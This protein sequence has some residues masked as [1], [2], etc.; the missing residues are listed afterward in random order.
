[1]IF[2]LAAL[3]CSAF[4]AWWLSGARSVAYLCYYLS[5]APFVTLS[6]T[7]GGLAG[8]DGF[9]SEVVLIKALLRVGTAA[10][11]VGLLVTRRSALGAL[12]DARFLAIPFFVLWATLGLVRG[13]DPSLGFLR[14]GEL[15][16]FVALGLLLW[17]ESRGRTLR[18]LLRW[19]ALA[20]LPLLTITAI[21]ARLDPG[22]ALHVAENG[23]VRA[24]NRLI[25]AESLGTAGALLTVWASYELQA[26]RS[27]ETSWWRERLLPTV[28]LV[29][30][31]ATLVLA[32]SRTAMLATVVAEVVLWFAT[33]RAS[34]RQWAFALTLL[35]GALVWGAFHTQ[36]IEAWV[37]RGDSVASLR[38]GTGRTELWAHLFEDSVRLHP[39]VGNGYIQLSE[40]GGFWHA[41]SYWTNAHNAYLAALLFAGI[42][43]LLAML[44]VLGLPLR[45]S[46]L[47]ARAAGAEHGAWRAV[48]ALGILAAINNATSFG[49]CG[50]PNPLMLFFFALYPLAVFG[51]QAGRAA[52]R[53]ERVDVN[54]AGGPAGARA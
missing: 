30:G 5:F 6:A 43:G 39:F 27:F 19:H 45:T 26:G 33:M 7:E 51:P 29:A 16:V 48:F 13:P 28:C 38:T 14:L 24:G 44:I 9:G 46:W 4:A 11:I 8:A 37:L 31:A 34:R 1:M 36:A 21:Y 2:G 49:I 25:N 53:A 32:R 52:P 42:P 17:S 40:T 41:G 23:L 15:T 54:E 47:R 3:I 35:L 10:L 18:T 12:A 20:L 50:W 22:L